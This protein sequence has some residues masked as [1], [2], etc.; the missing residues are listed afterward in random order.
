MSKILKQAGRTVRL[1]VRN[2]RLSKI[3][4][5]A[6]K[7]VRLEVRVQNFKRADDSL[8]YIMYIYVQFYLK[9]F[10]LLGS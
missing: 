2:R 3:L 1:E 9:N 10:L 8:L 5:P 6:G 4:K 7:T